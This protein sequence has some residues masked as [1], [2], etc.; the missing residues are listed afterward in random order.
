MKRE[1]EPVEPP[2]VLYYMNTQCATLADVGLS[3]AHTDRSLLGHSLVSACR[4]PGVS[5][6]PYQP[7]SFD[8]LRAY[9][10][11]DFLAALSLAS[12]ASANPHSETLQA[13]GLTHD[14][15]AFPGVLQYARLIAG[16]SLAAADALGCC[17][18][19]PLAPR[20]A[21]HWDGGR[22]HAR[23]DVAAGFCMVNDV[24]LAIQR[25]RKRGFRRVLY[26]DVDIHH[27][28]AVLEAFY[29]TKGLPE[30]GG[31]DG[32]TADRQSC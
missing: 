11:S 29:S 18:L 31:I 14:C 30:T 19:D 20:I 32:R 6:R 7:A 28:D 5:F 1:R 25:L 27:G 3:S 21:L 13:A 16:G 12:E 23:R 17:L 2:R 26:I 9:H 4:L 22:H 8:E 24:V 15:S 10:S